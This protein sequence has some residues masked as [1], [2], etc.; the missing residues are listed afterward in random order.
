MIV[1]THNFCGRLVLPTGKLFFSGSIPRLFFVFLF[2][3]LFC[4]LFLNLLLRTL[5]RNKPS[6]DSHN[7]YVPQAQN[8][9]QSALHAAA[10]YIQQYARV[11]QSENASKQTI[12]VNCGQ[13]PPYTSILDRGQW[14]R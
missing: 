12:K 9:L 10:K 5:Q 6:S 3:L 2:S 11:D 1:D 8:S 13:E 4:F 7:I 14:K